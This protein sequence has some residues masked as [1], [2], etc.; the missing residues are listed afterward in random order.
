MRNPSQAYIHNADTAQ[1][2]ALKTIQTANPADVA[3]IPE[4]AHAVRKA[5]EVVDRSDQALQNMGLL[6]TEETG[7]ETTGT[8]TTGTETTGPETTGPETT[9][10][11]TTTTTE[12]TTTTTTGDFPF[13]DIFSPYRNEQ[14]Y[15]GPTVL[16]VD[17]PSHGL[18]DYSQWMPSQG[19]GLLGSP[20]QRA[21][22]A[23]QGAHW[24]PQWQ[25]AG[26][27]YQPPQGVTYAPDYQ[28]VDQPE[29]VVQPESEGVDPNTVVY[30]L[31]DGSKTTDF[32][33]FTQ[34]NA[35]RY[36][37]GRFQAAQDAGVSGWR[38]FTPEGRA[39][40]AEQPNTS[41]AWIAAQRAAND[42]GNRQVYNQAPAPTNI[43]SP[44][45]YDFDQGPFTGSLPSAIS[46][47]AAATAAA[48]GILG[49]R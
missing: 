16:E 15:A 21:M 35:Q 27:G 33:K 36:Y 46:P 13:F 20:Q 11:T 25:D 14:R 30:T 12:P 40:T 4:V 18:L 8:E 38:A 22:F 24:Q 5:K 39:W 47:T 34:D 49:P 7:T 26:Y 42:A 41:A 2:R 32:M 44:V 6:G 9:G 3:T 48:M 29:R 19:S 10:T 45:N 43:F 31:S 28:T 23:N 1:A 17:A 37:P